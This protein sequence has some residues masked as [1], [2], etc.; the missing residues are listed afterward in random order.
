MVLGAGKTRG[1]RTLPIENSVDLANSAGRR[2]PEA[3]LSQD[4]LMG[5]VKGLAQGHPDR[6]FGTEQG[7]A[8]ARW[9]ADQMKAAGLSPVDGSY[10]SEF[11][12]EVAGRELIGKNVVGLL[13]G[14]D[15][16][17]KDEYIV[18]AAHHDS[19]HDTNEGANDNATGCA[20]VLAIAQALAKNPPKR[21][22]LF[23]TFDGEEGIRKDGKYFPGRRGSKAYAANPVV[24]VAKTALL[25]NMDMIGQVHLESGSRKAVYQWAS[26]DSFASQVLRRASREALAPDEEAVAGYPEQ[27]QESQ[28]FSTDAE[29]LYRL[30]VPTVNFLSGRDLDNHDPKDDMSRII[31][32]RMEQYA[33]L[34]HACV[35]EAANHA[36]SLQQMGITPGGLMPTY[37]LIRERKSAGLGT[38]EE[39]QIRLNDLVCRM[40]ELKA[41]AGR[42]VDALRRSKRIPNAAGVSL[43]ALQQGE[44]LASE[45]V[46]ARVREA[47]AALVD[48]LHHVNKNATAERR[49]L[50][51]RIDTL[52]GIEDVLQGAIYLTK[53][54]KTGAYYVKRVPERL[55]DLLRGAERLGLEAKLDGVVKESDVQIFTADVSADRAVQMARQALGGL[56]QAVGTAVFAM[57]APERAALEERPATSDEA[58]ALEAALQDALRE[59]A[60]EEAPKKEPDRTALVQAMLDAQIAGIRGNKER[61]L[62]TFRKHNVLTDFAE[63]AAALEIPGLKEKA[64]RLETAVETNEDLEAAVVDFYGALTLD[65][66]GEVIDSIEALSLLDSTEIEVKIA[67]RRAELATAQQR[68]QVDEAGDDPHVQRLAGLLDLVEASRALSTLFKKNEP[69]LKGNISLDLVKERLDAV[70][71]AAA[72]I[73]GGETVADEVSF[74]SSWLEQ[75]L[76]LQ[77]M[78]RNQ[79]R[80]RSKIAQEGLTAADRLWASLAPEVQKAAGL[81]KQDTRSLK[82]LVDGLRARLDQAKDAGIE[83]DQAQAGMALAGPML[84]V[85]QALAKLSNEPSAMAELTLSQAIAG[86]RDAGVREGRLAGI[87]AIESRL[88]KMHV[89]DDVTVGK[90]EAVRSG[91]LGILA[92]RA[93]Q[94][95]GLG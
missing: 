28:F 65:G 89:L 43:K 47:R 51:K 7:H 38:T 90:K 76:P 92:I 34:A 3:P 24:P 4:N 73:D 77:G 68:R 50:Q 6:V 10:F 46:L 18:V 40:P 9:M 94:E 95:E 75:F 55:A 30:G 44:P 93:A 29:P 41:A 13:E 62:S 20:G 53:I 61:W 17:L 66:F 79:A 69:V 33:R 27:P 1:N 86:L 84:G 35:V 88:R 25:L 72:K 2:L 15:P 5:L 81:E 21:S 11:S 70:A 32:E 59:V 67:V 8:S 23:V 78:A 22:V 80:Q 16:K 71:Q 49:G 60:G 12:W 85:Q 39:E 42:V 82:T 48:E 74:W 64:E 31:P 91:P 52:G 63:Q 57:M 26:G 56:G 54:E 87:A 36:E 45:P 58:Q 37:P 83:D 19:Q 14:T